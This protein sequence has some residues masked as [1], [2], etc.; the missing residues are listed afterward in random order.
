MSEPPLPGLP[1]P[2]EPRK[3]LGIRDIVLLTLGSGILIAEETLRALGIAEPS[4][5]M[6]AAAL[7]LLAVTGA[8]NADELL[9]RRK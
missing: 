4:A 2:P 1:P 9:R 5:P 6:I 3:R 8:L 7:S